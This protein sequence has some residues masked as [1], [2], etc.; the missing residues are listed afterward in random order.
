MPIS[1]PPRPLVRLLAACCLAATAAP[2]GGCASDGPGGMGGPFAE[3]EAQEL[4]AGA[5]TADWVSR[6]RV[7]G[8]VEALHALGE[9]L[10]V[11][12][13]DN[14][15]FRITQNGGS[16]RYL[17]R[18]AG[19]DE[20]VFGPVPVQVDGEPAVAF[21]SVATAVAFDDDGQMLVRRQLDFAFSGPA[22]SDGARMYAGFSTPQGGQVGAVAP[23][24][25]ALPIQWRRLVFGLVTGRPAIHEGITYVAT[26]EVGGDRGRVY[27][28]TTE[29]EAVWV[30][31][32][33]PYV[34]TFAGNTADLSA[35]AFGVY[36]PSGD[37][38]LYVY[39]RLNGRLK[40]RYYGGTALTN[41]AVPTADRV[42]L[43]IDGVGLVALEKD[44]EEIIKQATWTA[45]GVSKFLGES[46]DLVLGLKADGRLVALDRADGSERFASNAGGFVD[47]VPATEDGGPMF[48][49]TDGGAV[50]KVGVNLTPGK[51]GRP[52]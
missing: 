50:V 41:A 51:I 10:V 2:L 33:R 7:I 15:A 35:D 23:G 17:V 25:D 12:D 37:T 9:D 14:R 39:D 13:G 5:F 34:E 22:V 38:Q 1:V 36:V 31:G 6:L 20:R 45:T 46:G 16:L 19:G 28:I 27:A 49:V 18:V 26:G 44:G 42:Y 48:A 21:P 32:D 40:W 24:A 3:I 43:P 30:R 4:A 11:L 8:G 52:L 29:G 47:V